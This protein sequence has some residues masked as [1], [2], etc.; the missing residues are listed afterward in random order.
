MPKP[1]N[2]LIVYA[3]QPEP[4]KVKTRL[5]AA[6][7]TESA[8]DIYLRFMDTLMDRIAILPD[9]HIRI[10]YEPD[11][12]QAQE[13]F[14]AHYPNAHLSAQTPGDLGE[15]MLQSFHEGFSEGYAKVC[16]IGTD[17]PDV[18]MQ[19]ITQAYQLLDSHDLVLGPS[20]DGGYYLI[21]MKAAH[22]ELFDGFRWS[23]GSVLD[24]TLDRAREAALDTALV[25]PW[26]DV[27][28]IEGLERLRIRL[29]VTDDVKLGELKEAMSMIN[30]RGRA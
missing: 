21:A 2:L 7:G 14:H 30:P 26:D 15:R 27:D 17:I 4:G 16:L 3:R 10:D 8:C 22:R 9:I 12:A 18:P 23:T 5:S 11:T 28:D 1:K 20:R 25:P 29:M 13:Y 6:I 19:H 24:E